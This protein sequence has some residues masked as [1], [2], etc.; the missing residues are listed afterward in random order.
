VQPTPCA[1]RAE[2]QRLLAAAR[3]E[4]HKS[5]TAGP[6]ELSIDCIATEVQAQRS[7]PS[8]AS[9]PRPSGAL[10]RLHRYRGAMCGTRQGLL[11]L[12]LATLATGGCEGGPSTAASSADVDQ[13]AW[14]VTEAKGPAPLPRTWGFNYD[15]LAPV[16]PGPAPV[17]E[18]LFTSARS[19]SLPCIQ[20]E[21]PTAHVRPPCRLA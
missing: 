9:L 4:K 8:T 16:F 3:E 2:T 1:R 13:H 12:L 15:R 5:L 10:H 18:S 6:A 7:S 21:H 11:W 17:S 20:L 19:N 14:L